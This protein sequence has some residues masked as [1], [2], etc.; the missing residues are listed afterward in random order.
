MELADRVAR[1]VRETVPDATVILH[2]SL[3]TGEFRPGESDVDLLV[4]SDLPPGKTLVAAVR[5]A[6]A[7]DPTPVDLDV[8]TY[9]TAR[10]P[11][12]EPRLELYLR[13]DPARGERIV[14]DRPPRDLVVVFSLCNQLGVPDVGP[15]PPEWVDAV[16]RAQI[17]DWKRLPFQPEYAQLMAYTACRAWRFREERIHCGKLDAARW[18]EERGARVAFDEQSVRALLELASP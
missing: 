15:V 11:T 14:D 17:E 5:E 2:G 1:A 13:C 6:W 8:V 7:G 12:P 16:G 18:A 4:L 9:E 10:H 3:A